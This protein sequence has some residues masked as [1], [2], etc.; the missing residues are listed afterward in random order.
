MKKF[1]LILFI[2][3]VLFTGAYSQSKTLNG[4]YA[5]IEL[6][7]PVVMGAG[8]NRSD[9]VIYFRPDGTFTD[10]LN[11][12]DWKT[13][14][15]GKYQVQG[16]KINLLY[17]KG[18][19]DVM[20]IDKD[21][22][23]DA[24]GFNMLKLSTINTVPPG[25]YKFNLINGYGGGSM[26]SVQTANSTNLY[27]DGKGNFSRDQ[28][29]A[30]VISGEGVGGG[31]SSKKS[32]DGTYAIKAGQLT[33]KYNDGRTE[34]HSFFSRPEEKP[35]MAAVDGNIYFMEDKDE[36][37]KTAN[38]TARRR[39]NTSLNKAEPTGADNDS[40]I[41]ANNTTIIEKARQAQG[42]SAL[43]A[44]STIES[45]A[46]VSGFNGIT[47]LDV[48]NK[49]VRFE[50][51]KGSSIISVEQVEG[52]NGWIWKGGKKTSL[53]TARLNEMKQ[54]FETGIMALTKNNLA[55]LQ[56]AKIQSLKNNQTLITLNKNGG[57][58]FLMLSSDGRLIG[59]GIKRGNS[60]Q[61]SAYTN[62]RNVQG[63]LLPFKEQQV[64]GA[65]KL[66]IVYTNYRINPRF[67]QAE[68]DVPVK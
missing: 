7:L 9:E 23:L 10:Q 38:A 45:E 52:N 53:N 19:K 34:Q 31:S 18:A 13:H 15:A 17:N 56:N 33:L 14:V 6:T 25:F 62:L 39:N 47:R 29:N 60:M 59:E 22:N 58:Y 8:M 57:I 49:R 11:K 3:I 28:H 37:N 42:G 51:R 41:N 40:H 55:D 54:I 5:G 32:G 64:Q 16:N 43:D 12:S 4:V 65:N 1:A 35:I 66:S 61:T 48:N 2:F 67:T 46:L 24:G 50:L 26:A 68:W 30:T 21:G 63:I 27:F 20:T 44:I 36:A